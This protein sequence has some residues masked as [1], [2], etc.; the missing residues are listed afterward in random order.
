[1]VDEVN[2]SDQDSSLKFSNKLLSAK[3]K[4]PNRVDIRNSMKIQ[5]IGPDIA[6]I[7]SSPHS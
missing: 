3:P 4:I 1:M 2:F 6:R 5:N 7:K